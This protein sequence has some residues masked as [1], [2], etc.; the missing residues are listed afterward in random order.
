MDT[1]LIFVAIILVLVVAH[2]LGHFTVAKLSGISVLEFGVGLPPRLFA[3]EFGG[4]VYS[5][6]LLPIGGFVRM[7][8]EEDPTHP[9]SFA[10]K[11]ALTRLAVLVAGPAVNAVLPI[12]LLTFALMV[13]HSVPVTDIVVL[14]VIDGSPAAEAGVQ[15]GDFIREA[16]GRALDNSADLVGAVHRRL[17]ADISWVVERDGELVELRLA[18]VRID[19]PEGQGATGI[20]LRDAR[21]T[22]ESVASGSSAESVGLLAGDL[23]LS[24]AGASVLSEDAPTALAAGAL[25]AA[26]GE[27][28][29]ILVIRGGEILELSVGPPVSELSGYTVSVYPLASRS[30]PVWRAA[31]D[32]FVQMADILISFRNEI[33]R[34]IAGSSDL[35]FVGPVGIAQITGEVADAGLSPLITLAALLSINL[36]IV[37]I[38]PFPALDGGRIMFVLLELARGGRRISPGKERT[39]HLV[40]FGLLM[41]FIL[42][43]SINDIQRLISGAGPFG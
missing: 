7:L 25:E 23:F 20:L 5:V 27:S 8:G 2:E 43:I 42:M 33:S 39:A 21:L 31:G 11:G 12:A 26:P 22:V 9:T 15:P 6:N 40:G 38:L 37:N 13:P 3:F 34:L 41:T 17:G 29:E 4:T 32:S 30:R 35:G 14:D 1:V 36:A 16:D 19:P 28:V 10:S 18:E 24:V